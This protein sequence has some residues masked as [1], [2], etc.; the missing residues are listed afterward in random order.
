MVFACDDHFPEVGRRNVVY[1]HHQ[2]CY[3]SDGLKLSHHWGTIQLRTAQREAAAARRRLSLLNGSRSRQKVASPTLMITSRVITRTLSSR[4]V[5]PRDSISSFVSTA[6][7]AICSHST[8]PT[9]AWPTL[10]LLQRGTTKLYMHFCET[11]TSMGSAHCETAE[12]SLIG[13]AFAFVRS[14]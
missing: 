11:A 3:K 8:Q 2:F 13:E 6:T 9:A 10:L 1:Y 4:A 5:M 14:P 7:T 12:D